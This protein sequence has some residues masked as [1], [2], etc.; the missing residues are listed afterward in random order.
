M[1]K[2]PPIADKITLQE[3]IN[4]LHG[5]IRQRADDIVE[6]NNLNTRLVQGRLRTDLSAAPSAVTVNAG[7]DRE[8]DIYRDGSYEYIV[9]NDAGTLKWARQALDVGW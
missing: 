1:N 6:I 5:I 4:Y 2:F 8:G 7:I 3:V 9:V